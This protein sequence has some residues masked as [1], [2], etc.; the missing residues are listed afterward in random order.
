T[1]AGAS[2]DDMSRLKREV[3]KVSQAADTRIKPGGLF[4]AVEAI[5]NKI[6]DLGYAE[7][8]LRNMALVMQATGASGVAVGKV[9]AEMRKMGFDS[10]QA[11]LKGIDILNV[12]GKKGA[13]DLATLA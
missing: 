8:N 2:A 13:F 12:Q 10:P 7:R 5:V 4:S 9:F 11:V 6:G 1:D 3:F